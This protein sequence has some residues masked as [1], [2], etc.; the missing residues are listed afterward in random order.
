MHEFSR[1]YAWISESKGGNIVESQR[2][3]RKNHLIVFRQ[4][5]PSCTGNDWQK[6]V[7]KQTTTARLSGNP[8]PVLGVISSCTSTMHSK[9]YSYLCSFLLVF[10]LATKPVEGRNC[11]GLWHLFV[12]FISYSI[13]HWLSS[14]IFVQIL[15]E[16]EQALQ[17]K[18]SKRKDF[19]SR[20]D[21]S[22]GKREGLWRKTKKI[23]LWKEIN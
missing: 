9:H 5:I 3:C 1:I 22:Q 2:I 17:N 7:S 23:N 10:S 21:F 20:R 16:L 12:Y 8:H 14:N 4:K 18:A 11:Q 13:Q 15:V 19:C 6:Q